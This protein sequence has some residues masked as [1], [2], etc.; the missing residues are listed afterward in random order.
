MSKL[1]HEPYHTPRHHR[2]APCVRFFIARS[3]RGA[4]IHRTYTGARAPP[5][6]APTYPGLC[7]GMN[8]VQVAFPNF[9][10]RYTYPSRSIG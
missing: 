2:S 9:T 10:L 3:L 4:S 7:S 1:G 8:I 6:C 5:H